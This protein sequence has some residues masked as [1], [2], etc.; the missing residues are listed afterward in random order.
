M[1][2]ENL[3]KE[4]VDAKKTNNQNHLGFAGAV[5][6]GAVGTNFILL[7]AGTPIDVTL[8]YT[9]LLG[10]AMI[11]NRINKHFGKRGAVFKKMLREANKTATE[12]S[13]GNINIQ[14]IQSFHKLHDIVKDDVLGTKEKR[15]KVA[16]EFN[17][18]SANW[19]VGLVMAVCI[20]SLA[21]KGYNLYREADLESRDNE[22]TIGVS[23]P[24]KKR[25][26]YKNLQ[27]L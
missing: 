19:A 23:D 11:I 2:V 6:A 1:K 4:I 9:L 25:Q 26:K 27:P 21:D 24:D 7:Q 22:N 10:S 3:V 5:I 15:R 17:N 18:R 12:F 20:I 14:D 13:K 8:K 16:K